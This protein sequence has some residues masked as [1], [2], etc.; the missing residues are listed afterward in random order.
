MILTVDEILYQSENINEQVSAGRKSGAEAIK[1]LAPR[2][3]HL[4]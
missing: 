2:F 1:M 3:S 4:A